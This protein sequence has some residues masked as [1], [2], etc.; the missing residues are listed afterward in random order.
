LEQV[1]PAQWAALNLARGQVYTFVQEREQARMSLQTALSTLATLPDTPDNRRTEARTCR[2]LGALLRSEA[3]QEALYWV[4]RGLALLEDNKGEEA[5]SL[6]LLLADIHTKLGNIAQAGEA[7]DAALPM[8]PS[9]GPLRI[10]ALTQLSNLARLQGNHAQAVRD[11]LEAIRLAEQIQDNFAL[12]ILWGNLGIDQIY[13]GE[14][15]ASLASQQ[16]ALALARQLGNVVEQIRLASNLGSLYCDLGDDETAARYLFAALEQA[17]HQKTLQED[18]LYI[19]CMLTDFHLRR[20][21]VTQAMAA[22]EEATALANALQIRPLQPYIH[23]FW[24]LAHLA[25]WQIDQAEAAVTAALALALE[26]DNPHTEGTCLRTK[27]QVLLARGEH[28]EALT[29]FARSAGLFANDPYGAART[30]LEWAR[31]LLAGGANTQAMQLLAEAGAVF[32]RLGAQR[33]MAIVRSMSLA[34]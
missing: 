26:I 20:N 10:D 2:A 22:L 3:S 16:N 4:Q 19:Q 29:A 21:E 9:L 12:G 8:I 25:Q 28:A 5:V 15:E 14:W 6:N 30:R 27:G 33:E 32:E 17:R 31:A 24:A 11:G 18:L 34:S 13:L 1:N 7:L 23:N